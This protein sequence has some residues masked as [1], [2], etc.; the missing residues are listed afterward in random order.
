M[1]DSL[2]K[3]SGRLSLR[4]IDAII[5][6]FALAMI[7]FTVFAVNIS[8]RRLHHVA[9]ERFART[10]DSVLFDIDRQ[11]RGATATLRSMQGFF[12][13]SDDVTRVEFYKFIESSRVRSLYPGFATFAYMRR[14]PESDREAVI[15]EVRAD[16]SIKEEGYPEF[17]FWPEGIRTE[18]LPILYVDSEATAG[19]LLG[20]DQLVEPARARNLLHARDMGDLSISDVIMLQPAG[21]IGLII[22]APLYGTEDTPTTIEE[23]RTSFTGAITAALYL[24]DFFEASIPHSRLQELGVGM[25]ATQVSL[26]EAEAARTLIHAEVPTATRFWSKFYGPIVKERTVAFDGP[27]FNFT[28]ST[29]VETQLSGIEMIE[30]FGIGVILTLLTVALIFALGFVRQ[31][32]TTIELRRRHGFISTLSHQLRTPLTRMRWSLD[33]FKEKK[34]VAWEECGVL[35]DNLEELNSMMNKLLLF[36]ELGK[37]FRMEQW[38]VAS[39]Q[40]LIEMAERQLPAHQDRKRIQLSGSEGMAVFVLA[41]KEKL[42]MAVSFIIDNGLTYSTAESPVVVDVRSVRD[43]KEVEMRIVDEG[44]GIPAA[45]QSK[46]F[47]EFFRATNASRGKNA[48]SSVSLA[49]AKSVI[50]GHGGSVSFTSKEGDGSTFVVRLPVARGQS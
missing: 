24:E 21:K 42:A 19:G 30:P 14:V 3:L 2:K 34:I 38:E 4:G 39:V 28:F 26:P 40:E 18:Y 48:G 29:L 9:E 36:L 20:I 44:N 13:G 7:V 46:V 16:T 10:V 8:L 25:T 31:T 5:V 32:Q 15:D 41:D 6:G 49:I 17:S 45:E 35:Q 33:A 1:W 27:A 47:K 37:T 50:E 43:G 22:A 11:Y 23:R 12:A